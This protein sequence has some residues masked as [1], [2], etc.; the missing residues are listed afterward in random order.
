M[1][2][3][4]S[5]D[6]PTGQPATLVEVAQKAGVN[7]VTASI[8][9][10]GGRGNT[11]VSEKTRQRILSVAE[12]LNYQP[13]AIAQSLRR[14]KTGI[15][16]FYMSGYLDTRDLFLSEIVSGLHQGC[17][18]YD[19]D[20]LIHG[21]YRDASVDRIYSRLL[22]GKVDG[23][24]LHVHS[25]DPL[26]S[27]LADSYLPVVAIAN[28][29]S[30][31][32]C[33]TVDDVAGSALL[34]DH[35][36]AKGHRRVHYAASPYKL[37]AADRR[38]AAFVER[39]LEMGLEVTSTPLP[40]ETEKRAGSLDELL[41]APASRRPSAI[42]CWNDDVAYKT[43]QHLLDRGL[44]VP[45]DMAVTGFDGYSSPI[46]P[47]YALTTVRAPWREVAR[48]G[49]EIL[50]SSSAKPSVLETVLGVSLLT[51]ETT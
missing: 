15:I 26:L 46:P 21:T 36:A 32:P 1:M 51:G 4:A 45:D 12:E 5:V 49:V 3:D 11:R 23:L 24:V 7:K 30:L 13:N 42:V 10:S 17:E 35:L 29:T 27:R 34:L 43:I 9:L 31:L 6:P 14:R 41:N 40:V 44:R 39:G 28:P 50:A 38:Q 19:R 33:V 16:G 22:D 47:A 8:V 48:R 37:S 20:F 2:N 18:E 25:D